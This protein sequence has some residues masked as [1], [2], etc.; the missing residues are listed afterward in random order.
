MMKLTIFTPTYNRE[1]LI[2]QLYESLCRQTCKEFVWMIVDDGSTD[3]TKEIVQQWID[4]KEIRVEYIYQSNQGKSQAHNTGVLHCE[5]ELFTC[6]D[7]DDYLVDDAVKS[8]LAAWKQVSADEQVAGMVSPRQMNGAE[9]FKSSIPK[10]GTLTELYSRYGFKGETML[11]FRT[12]VLREY[13]FPKIVGERFM[14]ES[15]VYWK[16]DRKYKLLYLN[17][18]LCCGEYLS[19]GLTSQG[20]SREKSNPLSTLV[21]YQTGAEYSR[22]FYMRAKYSGCYYAWKSCFHINN[23][24]IKNTMGIME[25]I[26]G[27]L[28]CLHYKRLFE[29]KYKL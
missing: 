14:K 23:L 1:S 17:V 3:Q 4:K 2:P 5:T 22:S 15:V 25:R 12:A 7:S 19:D 29:R 8:I 18:F 9:L 10:Y 6:V 26:T 21:Y 28:I 13:L 24:P 16:I 11:I 27:R 20:I